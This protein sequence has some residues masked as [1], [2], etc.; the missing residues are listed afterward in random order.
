MRDNLDM[1]AFK[2]GGK[3]KVLGYISNK[4]G[5]QSNVESLPEFAQ[6]GAGLNE[7]MLSFFSNKSTLNIIHP[8]A[9]YYE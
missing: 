9:I 4:I 8:I 3:I 2:Y 1:S 6:I 5:D 7:A